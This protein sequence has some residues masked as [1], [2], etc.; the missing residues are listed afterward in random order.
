[1]PAIQAPPPGARDRIATRAPEPRGKRHRPWW[2]HASLVV[3]LL[4]ALGIIIYVVGFFM[5]LPGHGLKPDLPETRIMTRTSSGI[6][7]P[8]DDGTYIQ[9]SNEKLYALY[10]YSQITPQAPPDLA[11]FSPQDMRFIVM[12][13]NAFGYY[14]QYQLFTMGAQGVL[15]PVASDIEHIPVPGVASITINMAHGQT[16]APGTY[17]L[18]IPGDGMDDEDFW[19]YFAIK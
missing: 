14:S 8:V 16:W 5:L 17:A 13:Q 1:M 11:T 9:T 4:P 10:A 12:R 15:H 6:L 3:M 7:E 18:N 2:Q 19:Y